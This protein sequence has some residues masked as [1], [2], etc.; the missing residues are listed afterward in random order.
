MDYAKVAKLTADAGLSSSEVRLGKLSVH[1]PRGD[2]RILPRKGQSMAVILALF[3]LT[4]RS[5]QPL[6]HCST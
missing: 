2:E 4:N 3:R 5:R 6:L 1:D